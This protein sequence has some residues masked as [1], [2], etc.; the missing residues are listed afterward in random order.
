MRERQQTSII[1]ITG[2]IIWWISTLVIVIGGWLAF[3]DVSM[4]QAN[5]MNAVP[6]VAGKDDLTFLISIAFILIF[7]QA[8]S[9]LALKHLHAGSSIIWPVLLILLSFTGNVF[10][11]IPGLSGLIFNITERR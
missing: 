1:Q 2:F 5:V 7:V 10:Y 3:M 4:R 8:A 6:G 11:I 9:Y